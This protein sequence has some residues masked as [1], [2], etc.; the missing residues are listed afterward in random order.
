FDMLWGHRR[1]IQGYAQGLEYFDSRLPELLPILRENDLVFITAD[2]GCDPSYKGTDHTREQVPALMF[3][4]KVKA[5]N[6]GAR[7]TYA[8]LGQTVAAHLGIAPLDYGT[9]FL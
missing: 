6:I 3:G 2:H 8:D 9:S 4:H 5:E 7:Q 1:N